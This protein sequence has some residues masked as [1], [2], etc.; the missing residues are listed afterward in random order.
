MFDTSGERLTP[1]HTQKRGRRYAYYISQSLK[2]GAASKERDSGWRLPARALEDRVAAAV[3]R[4]LRA[5]VMR[6]LVVEADAKTI[7]DSVAR[8]GGSDFDAFAPIERIFIGKEGLSITLAHRTTAGAL[9]IAVEAIVPER[10]SFEVPLTIR[11]RGVE[12][13]LLLHGEPLPQDTTLIG[14]IAKGHAYLDLITKGQSAQ[15]IAEKNGISVK[16]VQQIIEFA[17]LG[18]DAVRQI[19]EGR[20]PPFLT[21]DWCLKHEIAADWAAQQMLFLTA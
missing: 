7:A 1:V 10:L 3:L 14:N 6:G 13:K 21:A 5:S 18:P 11:R 8:I 15:A 19:I 2:V 4:H 16:R 17:F 12:T 20:Q 9:D